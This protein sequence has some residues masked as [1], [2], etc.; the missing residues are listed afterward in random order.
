VRDGWD[1]FQR[2][3]TIAF[4]YRHVL[5]Y[6]DIPYYKNVRQGCTP[7]QRR[8]SEVGRCH[9]A[10]LCMGA[11]S[12]VNGNVCRCFRECWHEMF[13]MFYDFSAGTLAVIC[14]A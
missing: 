3:P 7:F 14:Y 4:V 10:V 6:V 13:G 5:P 9:A 12:I 8:V 2:E 1:I 11:V